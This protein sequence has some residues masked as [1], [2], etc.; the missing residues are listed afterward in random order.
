MTLF[1]KGLRGLPLDDILVIDAH[2]HFGP[3]RE[4]DRDTSPARLLAGMDAIGID[5]VCGMAFTPTAGATLSRHNDYVYQFISN[6]PRRLRGYCWVNP[7][8]PEFMEREL[9]R[10]FDERGFVGI[11]VHTHSRHPYDGPRYAP[12]YEFANARKLPVLAHTWGDDWLRQFA[13]MA[14]KYPDAT[15]LA[16]HTGGGDISVSIEEARRTPN[17]HLELCLSAGTPYQVEYLVREVGA[18]RLVWG[19]DQML[20]SPGHQ[21]G[22]VLFADIAEEDKRRILG[23]NAQRIFGIRV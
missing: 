20:M 16:G 8:Y 22:R 17:L 23:E 13:A 9:A 5:V 1:E 6:C 19:S 2:A 14:R 7:N 11:K 4:I 10:C 15:F 3:R 12:V 18:E 21:I